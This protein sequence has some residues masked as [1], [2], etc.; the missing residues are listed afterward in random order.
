MPPKT[1]QIKELHFEVYGLNGC[2]YYIGAVQTLTQLKDSVNTHPHSKKNIKV[3]VTVKDIER[4]IWHNHI[5]QV[6]TKK[7]KTNKTK[8][9]SHKTSPFIMCNG[10]FIGGYDS[11]SSELQKPTPFKGI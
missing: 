2:P 3:K 11:L 9:K 1:N 4:N 8:A 10:H 5:E 6:C 7:V